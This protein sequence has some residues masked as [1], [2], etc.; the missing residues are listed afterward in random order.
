VAVGCGGKTKEGKWLSFMCFNLGA[1]NTSTIYKQKN[2]SIS[3]SNNPVTG[4]HSHVLNEEKVYGDLFQWGR[5]PDG[6]EKRTSVT[7]AYGTMSVSELANG[8]WCSD[9]DTYGRPTN[10]IKKSSSWYGKSIT[11]A[12]AGTNYNWNPIADQTV[13]DGLWTAGRYLPNDPCAHYKN[14]GNY[15][16]F[17][18]A[19]GKDSNDPACGSSSDDWRLPTQSEWGELYRG[20]AILGSPVDAEANTWS[21]Y[22]AL[23]AGFELRPDNVTTTLFLPASGY[24]GRGDGLLYYQASYAYYWSSTIAGTNAYSL[25][26]N[27]G[28]INPADGRNRS[29]SFALRCIKN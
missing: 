15:H 20:G 10:Q 29:S 4:E 21:W 1:D 28:G 11:G 14:D 6:H 16:E 12:G 5:I 3:F 27:S 7:K 23:P 18:H 13:A 9:T 8:G 26:F 17:W 25:F 22:S 2:Y 24:R 19:D